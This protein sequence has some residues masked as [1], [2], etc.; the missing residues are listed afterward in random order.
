LNGNGI[1]G[2][3]P[4]MR[5]VDQNGNLKHDIDFRSVYATLMEDWLCAAPEVVDNILGNTF[6][7]VGPLGFDCLNVSGTNTQVITNKVTHK[8]KMNGDGSYTIEYDLERPGPV[9]VNIYTIMGQKIETIVN[10]YQSAGKH[11]ALY[12][13]RAFGLSAAIYIYNIQVA[14][15]LYS[16][17]FV[18]S[19]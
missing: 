11:E 10:E 19:N 2:D 12:I 15:K 9:I 16:G 6:D 3:G 14:G 13:N 1:L 8:A 4:D 5:N 17:K 18:V 7:R